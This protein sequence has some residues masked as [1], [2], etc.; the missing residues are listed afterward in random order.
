MKTLSEIARHM[1]INIV[2][3]RDEF[4]VKETL[5]GKEIDLKLYHEGFG[6]L[7]VIAGGFGK[8]DIRVALNPPVPFANK[9]IVILVNISDGGFENVQLPFDHQSLTDALITLLEREDI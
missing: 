5:H 6:A 9:A 4:S 2:P 8:A 7:P 1:F 3:P